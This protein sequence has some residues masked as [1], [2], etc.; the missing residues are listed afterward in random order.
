MWNLCVSGSAKTF[1]G[2]GVEAIKSMEMV[3]RGMKG[4]GDRADV[5]SRGCPPIDFAVS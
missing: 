2:T 5:E 4:W 1:V 3:P